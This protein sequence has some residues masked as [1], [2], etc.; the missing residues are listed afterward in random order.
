MADLTLDEFR[1]L[2]EISKLLLQESL[3]LGKQIPSLLTKAAK[4]RDEIMKVLQHRAST[5]SEAELKTVLNETSQTHGQILE[6]TIDASE[7]LGILAKDI[8]NILS[9][10]PAPDDNLDPQLLGPLAV[11]GEA[12]ASQE[13]DTFLREYTV[14][15]GIFP[16]VDVIESYIEM[17]EAF[18]RRKAGGL[19]IRGRVIHVLKTFLEDA[20]DE[21]K[22]PFYETFR[23]IFRQLTTSQ[24]KKDIAELTAESGERV[25]TLRRVQHT[26]AS[27]LEFAQKIIQSDRKFGIESAE[28]QRTAIARAEAVLKRL[29]QMK[30]DLQQAGPNS[31]FIFIGDEVCIRTPGSP[32]TDTPTL[33]TKVDVEHAVEAG[34]VREQRVVGSQSWTY[35]VLT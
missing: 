22:P 10:P 29:Q 34:L 19:D 8:S 24:I 35:Y 25:Y 4:G 3:E 20:T 7:D 26:V 6:K 21:V 30:S 28:H 1:Q 13:I 9:G 12:K 5:A 14:A 33:Y 23:D 11:L 15:S 32:Y 16:T 17:N 31:G 2:R 18:L 27:Q